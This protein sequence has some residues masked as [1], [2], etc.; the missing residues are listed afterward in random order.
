MPPYPVSKPL[1]S[2]SPKVAAKPVARQPAPPKSTPSVKTKRNEILI[3]ESPMDAFGPSHPA[4]TNGLRKMVLHGE[5]FEAFMKVAHSN[6]SRKIE[7]C[8]I[9]A[10]NLVCT[11]F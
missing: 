2:P 8:G 7:T 6:T 1:A 11:S 10:G 9:L 5:M 3:E 4:N